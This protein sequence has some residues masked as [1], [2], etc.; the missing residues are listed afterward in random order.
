MRGQAMLEA[1]IVLPVLLSIFIALFYFSLRSMNQAR[2]AM[3]ARHG[4]WSYSIGQGDKVNKRV[5]AFFADSKQVTVTKKKQELQLGASYV[6]KLIDLLVGG[7]LKEN[8][9]VTVTYIQPPFPYAAPD[10][11][12]DGLFA[13]MQKTVK[14]EPVKVVFCDRT[15][16]W[17][18]T[19][20]L[21]LKILGNIFKY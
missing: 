20:K 1:A 17:Q 9:A 4:A 13:F 8:S 3:A 21:L 12:K 14:N 5:Y 7:T 11:Q 19:N 15:D 16:Y 10:Q 18:N 6:S 2:A